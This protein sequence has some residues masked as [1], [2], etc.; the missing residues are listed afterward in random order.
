MAITSTL[1]DLGARGVTAFHRAV[2]TASNGRFAGKMFGMPV[3]KLTTTG[4]KSGQPRPTMLTAPVV[5]GDKVVL[6]A[7]YGGDDRHP[8]WYLNLRDQPDVEIVM[9]GRVRP[10]RA[11]TAEAAEKD[12]LWPEIVKAYKGYG[13]YQRRTDR[14]IPVVVLEPRTS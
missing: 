5:D 12:A 11:R 8:A 13:G 2:F 3:V 7:S 14:D 10:M 4:R 6:V 9:Q 1:K